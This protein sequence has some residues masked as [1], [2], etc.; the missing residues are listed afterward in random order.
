MSRGRKFCPIKGKKS[1]K[2]IYYS[3]ETGFK[4]LKSLQLDTRKKNEFIGGHFIMEKPS[5]ARSGR[6]WYVILCEVTVKA[7]KGLSRRLI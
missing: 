5:N 1:R 4:V 3:P 7:L 6:V 2:D